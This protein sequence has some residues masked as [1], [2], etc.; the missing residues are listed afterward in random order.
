MENR[1][2]YHD[3]NPFIAQMDI[4]LIYSELARHKLVLAT[5]KL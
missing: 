5:L 3:F 1:T 4:L 2:R